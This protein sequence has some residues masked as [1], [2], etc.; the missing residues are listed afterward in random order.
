[1]TRTWSRL[2]CAVKGHQLALSTRSP[3]G[4]L[5]P[6]YLYVCDRC[7]EQVW[8]E[9]ILVVLAES[10]KVLDRARDEIGRA[11]WSHMEREIMAEV[12]E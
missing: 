2:V 9:N 5:A 11:M 4:M 10:D 3:K 1:M 6:H 12:K 8:E 7:G